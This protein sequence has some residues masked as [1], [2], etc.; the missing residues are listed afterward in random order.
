MKHWRTLGSV[1]ATAVLVAGACGGD[2]GDKKQ[3]GS[4]AEPLV[5][6]FKIDGGQCTTAGVTSGSSFR[7]INP[8]GKLGEGP[9]ISNGDSSCG[10]KTY[11]PMSPGSDGGM[12]IGAYQPEVSPPFDASGHGAT[13]LIAK[14]TPF[15]AVRFAVATNQKDPQ[16]GGNAPS[17]PSRSRTGRSPGTCRP[18]RPPG[19]T[20]TSTRAHPNP[21]GR[22]PA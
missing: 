4:G 14:G 20:S 5:G 6:L 15:F 1:L 12:R 13:E 2:D 8:G 21:T 11:S 3:A 16:T 7:M 22:S 17:R 19:T 10:D 9:F 18:S